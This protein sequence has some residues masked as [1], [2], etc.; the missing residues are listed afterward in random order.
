M[1]DLFA[2]FEMAEDGIIQESMGVGDQAYAFQT[3]CVYLCTTIV[4]YAILPQLH[5]VDR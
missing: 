4:R 3:D 1:P 2:R 5:L